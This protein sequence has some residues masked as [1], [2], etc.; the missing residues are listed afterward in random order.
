MEI[1]IGVD[2]KQVKTGLDALQDQFRQARGTINTALENV[3]GFADIKKQADETGKAYAAVQ[4][5]VAELAGTIKAFGSGEELAR[6]FDQA[7]TAAASLKTELSSASVAYAESRKR[8][9]ELAQVFKG[10][11]KSVAEDLKAARQESRAMKEDLDRLRAGYKEAKGEAA[12]LGQQVKATAA[13]F[14]EFDLAKREAAG[15][16]DKLAGQRLEAQRL[17]TALG[18]AGIASTD[19]GK[20]Q[21]KLRQ[22]LEQTKE[23][24]QALAKVA[25]AR[26]T[27]GIGAHADIQGQI[28]KTR[29][30]YVDLAT[31]GKASFSELA[32]AKV[33]MGTK[34][35]ELRS[36]TNGWK[37]SLLS[38]KEELI[39]IGVAAAALI[40]AARV[41]MQ[42][43]TS[44]ADVRKTVGGTKEEI[45][46]LG[47]EIR[48]MSTQIP[49]AADELAK[50]AAAGGQLGIAAQDIGAFTSMTAKMATAFDMTAEA[51]GES[52]GKIKNVYKLTIPEVEGLGDA[53]NQLGN[54]SAA[55]EK[56]IVNVMLRVGGTANQFGLAKEATA[57]LAA[58]MLALGRPAEVSGT[59]IN[60][61]L[62]NMQTATMGSKQ[63]KD[64]LGK[65]GMSAEEM[66]AMVAKDPQKALDH[67]LGTL[68]KLDGQQRAEVLTG[69]FG[70]EFQDDIGALIG[71]LE[72]YRDA[73]GQVADKTTYAGAMNEEFAAKTNTSENQLRLLKNTVTDIVRTIGDGFLPIINKVAGGLNSLLTPVADLIREFPKISA[74][75]ATVATGFLV[76]NSVKRLVDILRMAIA[77]I[78]PTS[79]TSFATAGTAA[80][81]FGGK[82]TALTTKAG[83]LKSVL[84]KASGVLMALGVG[85]EVG[86]LLNNFDIVRKGGATLVYGLDRVRLAAVKMWRALT[87]GDTAEIDREIEN[88]K[89]V[90]QEMLA[91]IDKKQDEWSKKQR[92]ELPAGAAPEKTATEKTA[93]EKEA[94]EK[95]AEKVAEKERMSRPSTPAEIQAHIER[96]EKAAAE[97]GLSET[98]PKTDE[99][100]PISR[101]QEA[102]DSRPASMLTDEQLKERKERLGTEL[103]TDEIAAK[104]KEEKREKEESEQKKATAAT[105][106]T[107]QQPAKLDTRTSR[108]Q[109]P[110]RR[111]DDDFDREDDFEPDSSDTRRPRDRK[112]GR[113]RSRRRRDDD[114]KKPK[115]ADGMAVHGGALTAEEW[116]GLTKEQQDE[117]SKKATAPRKSYDYFNAGKMEKRFRGDTD[118]QPELARS[119]KTMLEQNRTQAEQAKFLDEK[120]VTLEERKAEIAEKDAADDQQRV[121]RLKELTEQDKQA[122]EQMA[123]AAKAAEAEAVAAN[124]ERTELAKKSAE[125]RVQAEASA[126]EKS[127]SVFQKYAERVRQLQSEIAGREKSLAEELDDLDTTTPAEI[128][129]KR[130]AKAAKDYEAAAKK[131]M[132]AGNLDQALSLADRAKSLYSSLKDSPTGISETLARMTTT[133]GIRSSG[134]LGLD[135]SKVVQGSAAKSALAAV[136]AHLSGNSV[137]VIRNHLAAIAGS[138][139]TGAKG[140]AEVAKVHELRFKGGSLQGSQTDIEALLHHLAQAG[141]SAT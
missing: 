39:K 79:A 130:K 49:M 74:A 123:E 25:S 83:L 9:A 34:I 131:A 136:P 48:E 10:G 96:N 99:K 133:R 57:A 112:S 42:F 66:A 135:I 129:W 1:S 114:E 71:G 109:R 41:G 2:S 134:L 80:T 12:G 116:E 53:I 67:L 117:L 91:D 28:A 93:S 55:K 94:A 35:A 5:K 21:A 82:L 4:Q 51:A 13:T 44:M 27:L 113:G 140:S 62:N 111:R 8:V 38:A 106:Q 101:E 103:S 46:A 20:A 138:G 7:K 61:L 108:K 47:N 126:A 6:S 77:A 36:Q 102:I 76:F 98:E 26:E 127:K 84:G 14:R 16:K 24:Y 122:N 124:Q 107:D 125:E 3:K 78:G 33:A 119:A 70:K 63:F 50:I 30:A 81:G 87:G 128:K 92:G 95:T 141:L 110:E 89:K 59:A 17:R 40:Q 31:S 22:D 58:S 100:K 45:R 90:Y 97:K 32:Q 68:E 18:Q 54:N 19:M 72:T 65:I 105:D 56:D 120:I 88:A 115:A 52:I 75:L 23:K 15:L 69:L 29:Q 86:N 64:A 104:A 137:S 11:D 118:I 37:E 73:M 43:E 139:G 132:A 85:W 60:T 121:E